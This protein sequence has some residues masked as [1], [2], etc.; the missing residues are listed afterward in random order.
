M[1]IIE[2]IRNIILTPKTEWPVIEGE[3]TTVQ[4]LYTGYIMLL[5]TIP[6]VAGFIGMSVI[7]MNMPG[8]GSF[9]VPI[10]N[11]ITMLIVGYL[12]SLAMIYVLALIIDA[13]APNFASEKNF[14]QAFKLATYSFTASWLVGIFYLIPA[15]SVLAILGLYSLY[16]LYVGLPI[17]MKTPTD[18]VVGYFV[19]I[20]IVGVVAGVIVGA[21]MHTLT[22]NP[23]AGLAAGIPPMQ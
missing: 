22:P 8:F 1:N 19:V 14:I 6:A 18:K 7:G 10:M 4:G 5:A 17:M 20:L 21:V 12:L 16:V 13:M 15:L 11:G 23:M 9:R 3:A 2:R